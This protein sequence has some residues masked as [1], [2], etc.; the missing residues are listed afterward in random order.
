MTTLPDLCLDT[1]VLIAEFLKKNHMVRLYLVG[2]DKLNAKLRALRHRTFVG[3]DTYADT[4]IDSELV[5]GLLVSSSDHVETDW[6]N[7]KRFEED[8]ISPNTVTRSLHVTSQYHEDMPLDVDGF[9]AVMSRM[10]RLETLNIIGLVISGALR[11]P[12]TITSLTL[13]TMTRPNDI[14]CLCHL[15]LL[16]LSV[17][18]P[19]PDESLDWM[20]KADWH[21]S[22]TSMTLSGRYESLAFAADK[23]PNNLVELKIGLHSEWLEN[24][25]IAPI[26]AHQKQLK[27]LTTSVTWSLASPLP[28][29]LTRLDMW[30]LSVKTPNSLVGFSHIAQFIPPSVVSLSMPSI[31]MCCEGPIAAVVFPPA[32]EH[33]CEFASLMMPQ[34]DLESCLHFAR[35][36]HLFA[37]VVHRGYKSLSGCMTDKLKSRGYSEKHMSWL[38]RN[39]VVSKITANVDDH[40]IKSAFNQGLTTRKDMALF[41]KGKTILSSCSCTCSDHYLT[42]IKCLEWDLV[43]HLTLKDTRPPQLSEAAVQNLASVLVETCCESVIQDFFSSYTFGSTTDLEFDLPLD[44]E[45]KEM[46]LSFVVRTVHTLRARLPVLESICFTNW[47]HWESPIDETS[48]NLLAEMR[49]QYIPNTRYFRYSVKTVPA[50]LPESEIN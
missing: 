26:V 32:A 36:H 1:L 9:N 16:H 46:F 23:I 14:D 21:K 4:T 39:D 33:L 25:D 47:L 29:T 41:L 43:Q 49:L 40:W 22:L 38:D 5:S 44:V 7:L 18:L 42:T 10:Q 20:T 24:M 48:R 3:S 2:S 6:C 8:L 30:R 45:R 13:P 17:T 35:C 34:L 37:S 12:S 50:P 15:P 19:S 28:P 11:L 31:Q 27:S